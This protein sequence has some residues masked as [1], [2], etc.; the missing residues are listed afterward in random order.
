MKVHIRP[1]DAPIYESTET[2]TCIVLHFRRLKQSAAAK[3]E[4]CHST[5]MEL[6]GDRRSLIGPGGSRGQPKNLIYIDFSLLNITSF[7][8]CHLSGLLAT[9]ARLFR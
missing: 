7:L 3:D 5:E 4:W 1:R 8:F 2:L 9:P 6:A